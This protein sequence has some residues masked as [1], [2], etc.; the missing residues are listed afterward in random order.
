METSSNTIANNNIATRYHFLDVVRGFA[1]LSMILYHACFDLVYIHNLSIPWYTSS[2]GYYWQQSIC[3]ILIFISGMSWS[4]GKN[5]LRRGSVVFGFGFLII[6]IT[7]I[8]IPSQAVSLGILSFLGIAMLLLIPLNKL[9][10]KINCQIGLLLSLFLF[11]LTKKIY[12]GYLS[13]EPF[14]HL[15]L[16]D[17][18]YE[19]PGFFI[20][21]LPSDSFSSSDYYPIF[22]WLFLYIAGFY[23][24]NI[25]KNNT[26]ILHFLTLKITPFEKIGRNTLIIYMLHQPV[27]MAFFYLLSQLHVL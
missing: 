2:Y 4:L 5:P 17:W 23:F 7:H 24:W 15:E 19:I 10:L 8:F 13:I 21:G 20:L 18:I 22:P 6:L 1:L 26:R 14:F 16:P 27:L 25:I 9:L 12:Y 11:I 3:L